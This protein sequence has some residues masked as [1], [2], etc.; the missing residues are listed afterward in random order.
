MIIFIYIK[1]NIDILV[2]VFTVNLEDN[3]VSFL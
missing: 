3:Y 2:S 1:Q